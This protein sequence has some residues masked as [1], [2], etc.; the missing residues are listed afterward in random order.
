MFP[1]QVYN[2]AADIAPEELPL[3]SFEFSANGLQFLHALFS[4]HASSENGLLPVSQ[5]RALWTRLAELPEPQWQVACPWSDSENVLRTVACSSPNVA[6]SAIDFR[7]FVALWYALLDGSLPSLRSAA[8]CAAFLG[9]WHE[10]ETPLFDWQIF[11]EKERHFF[12]VAVACA[13]A[14]LG[15][16]AL[17][18]LAP[19]IPAPGNV[20]CLELLPQ[21]FCRIELLVVPPPVA[22]AGESDKWFSEINASRFDVAVC[23]HDD[24]EGSLAACSRFCNLLD[25]ENRLRSLLPLLFVN[26][27]EKDLPDAA[28]RARRVRTALGLAASAVTLQDGGD[29]FRQ[30]LA[31]IVRSHSRADPASNREHKV[32]GL[33]SGLQ[34]CSII[35]FLFVLFGSCRGAE[36]GA[37]WRERPCWRWPQRPLFTFGAAAAARRRNEE[38]K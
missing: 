7:N 3:A 12:V 5:L 34:I 25:S 19:G 13:D 14:S 4:R 15:R 32:R 26:V 27:S 16:R 31:K 21:I 37:G 2:W 33:E 24:S 17:A 35:F 1:A 9:F 10:K 23:A 11:G 18:A 36:D 28:A 20:I 22:A 38:L 6:L 29:E 30:R 8:R